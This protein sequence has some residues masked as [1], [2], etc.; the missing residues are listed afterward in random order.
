MQPV[1]Y[2]IGSLRNP[3]V[4]KVAKALR[5]QGFEVFDDWHAAGKIADDS[6]RDY[7][8]A[9][10]HSYSDA[11][12]G[13]A[14]RHVF[15]HDLF[16]LR[17][18]HGCVLVLPAGKSGHLEFGYVV[19]LGK[20]GFI[21]LNGEPERFDA[22]T[23]FA[24]S[25]QSTVQQC[26]QDLKSFP[27]PKIPPMPTMHADEVIPLALLLEGEG[28]F[29][30]G[31]GTT[32]RLV[33]QMTDEDVVRWAAKIL[34]SAVWQTTRTAVYKKIWACGTSGI[35]AAEWM[36][37]LLPYMKSRRQAQ[38]KKTVATWLERRTYN[39]RDNVVW[40]KWFGITEG[41]LN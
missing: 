39:R 37:V 5:K 4:S 15:H 20:P 23:Q 19:G 31:K 10:G 14:A 12:Q 25:V 27:W 40:A 35:R 33:L 3:E 41:D 8:Q 16:H 7:E 28:T 1:V 36:R 6:W 2:L 38:I 24:Y 34:D 22:M 29:S 9:K 17:R 13:H 11:L 18:S 32:P 26:V 21:L 30:I